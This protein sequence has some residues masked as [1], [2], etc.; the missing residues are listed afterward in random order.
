M[1]CNVRGAGCHIRVQVWGAGCSLWGAGCSTQQD[2]AAVKPVGTPAEPPKGAL[3]GISL[4]SHVPVED[5]H[6]GEGTEELLPA[7]L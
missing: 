1:G 2:P 5:A 3:W 6:R 7:S 4:S